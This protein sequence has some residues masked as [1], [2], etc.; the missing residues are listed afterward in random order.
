MGAWQTTGKFVGHALFAY[1][2][3]MFEDIRSAVTGR[4]FR[5]GRAVL[6][7]HRRQRIGDLV[8]P[9]VQPW[10]GES[11]EGVVLFGLDRSCLARIDHY[12]GDLYDRRLVRIESR[13]G[14]RMAFCYLASRR[15]RVL[16]GEAWCADEFA[17]C[18]KA[19]YVRRQLVPTVRRIR[20]A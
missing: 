5:I 16:L 12:E 20:S 19:D 1:G 14:S 17:R 8:V 13:G 9:A 6:P 11:V 7:D 18:H 10:T 4:R 2:T 3:L 15:A